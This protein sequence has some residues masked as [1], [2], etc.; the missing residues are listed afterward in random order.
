MGALHWVTPVKGRK[1]VYYSVHFVL[2]T[3]CSVC[4]LQ[5]S[6]N[7]GQGKSKV[8]SALRW[9]YDIVRSTGYCLPTLGNAQWAMPAVKRGKLGGIQTLLA[10]SNTPYSSLSTAPTWLSSALT[11]QYHAHHSTLPHTHGKCQRCLVSEN[12]VEFSAFEHVQ[13]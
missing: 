5:S 7:L 12:L 10:R 3:I 4:Y 6:K 11:L 2:F 13:A 1:C 9:L 8:E